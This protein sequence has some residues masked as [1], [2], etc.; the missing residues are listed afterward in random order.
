MFAAEPYEI[1]AFK[2]DHLYNK[3]MVTIWF[4][5]SMANQLIMDMCMDIV[6]S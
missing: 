4:F 6:G 1:I 2:V 5:F 3:I